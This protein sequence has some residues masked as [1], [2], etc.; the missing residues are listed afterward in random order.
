MGWPTTSRQSR[1][2]GRAW[3]IT[4]AR[5]LERDAHLCQPCK[6]KDRLTVG[7]EVHHITPKSK[8]GS[9]D[10]SNLETTCHP[11]HEEAD[12]KALGRTV[13][14]HRVALDGTI[15]EGDA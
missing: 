11:C 4:R 2:Y 7:N 12:A 9:D 10:D 1:G 13:K 3:E 6:R 5:I 15:I 14:R 8:G